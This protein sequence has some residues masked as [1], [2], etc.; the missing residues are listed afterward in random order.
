LGF[1]PGKVG[2]RRNNDAFF[3]VRLWRSRNYECGTCELFKEDSATT[4]ADHTHNKKRC[5]SKD[6]HLFY[7]RKMIY[8]FIIANPPIKIIVRPPKDIA[9]NIAQKIIL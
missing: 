6:K 8:F 1:N 4:N 5:F 3:V 7:L 2:R 9:K